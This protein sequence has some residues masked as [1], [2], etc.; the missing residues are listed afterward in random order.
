MRSNAGDL[1]GFVLLSTIS[2]RSSIAAVFAF[3]SSFLGEDTLI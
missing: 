3:F 1:D 2:S